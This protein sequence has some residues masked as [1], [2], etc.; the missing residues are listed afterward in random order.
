MKYPLTLLAAL[1]AGC[2]STSTPVEHVDVPMPIACTAPELPEKPRLA[3]EDLP[4]TAT[5]AETI[6]AYASSLRACGTYSKKLE[7]LLKV[8]SK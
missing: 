7:I 1:L 8:P 6:A 3:L 5:D 2:A 4:E